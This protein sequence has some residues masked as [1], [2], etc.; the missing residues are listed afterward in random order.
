MLM[1][2]LWWQPCF[3]FQNVSL[4]D[5]TRWVCN[6]CS[7]SAVGM[8]P[9]IRISS[10]PQGRLQASWA[11]EFA[12]A[13]HVAGATHSQRPQEG[14]IDFLT[15]KSEIN[16]NQPETS[17]KSTGWWIDMWNYFTQKFRNPYFN[18]HPDFGLLWWGE[19]LC[20]RWS[21]VLPWMVSIRSSFGSPASP[22]KS[23][24]ECLV[25]TCMGI[26]YMIYI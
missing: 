15:Q 2:C 7:V 25:A 23:D 24:E 26:L 13:S 14:S 21:Q 11:L 12:L 6:D 10:T 9:V 17:M 19:I 16:G 20:H 22:E 18:F 1:M 4:H 3:K 5:L 8:L